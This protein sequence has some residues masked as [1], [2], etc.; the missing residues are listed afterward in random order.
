MDIFI[1]GILG[2]ASLVIY[3]FVALA[4]KIEDGGDVF[5]RQNRIGKGGKT[6]SMFKFRSMKTSDGGKWVTEGDNRITRVGKFIR[7]S[8]IDELPQLW[9]VV[10]GDMSLI[11]P[12]PDIY[13]L[14]VKLSEE[15]PH[16]RIRSLVAPG[17]SGWA[18]IRQELPPQSL[19]ETKVRLSYDFY[20]VKSRSILLDLKIAL[21]T[22]KTLLMRVGK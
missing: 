13:D 18:Q 16:Y 11:G 2:I 6:I 10:K 22:I 20:Y 8:R 3:P 15:I 9:S 17:L 4:I 1:A 5:I 12:R 14:G 7:A 19:E 21:Q